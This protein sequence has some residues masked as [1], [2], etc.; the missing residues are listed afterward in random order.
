MQP[1]LVHVDPKNMFFFG[2]MFVGWL[3]P[4]R[5]PGLKQDAKLQHNTVVAYV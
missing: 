4:Q 1:L 3:V 2:D 5:F